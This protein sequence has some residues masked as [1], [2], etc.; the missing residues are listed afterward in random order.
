MAVLFGSIIVGNMITSNKPKQKSDTA[1]VKDVTVFGIGSLPTV[2][3]NATVEKQGV[4]SV[5]AQSAGIVQSIFVEEGNTVGKGQA[6]VWLSTNPSGGTIPSVTREI[7][8]KNYDFVSLNYDTQKELIAKRRE[9]SERTN[10]LAADT[11]DMTQDTNART[12]ELISLNEGI[13]S[14]L[15]SQIQHLESTNVG[16]ANESLILQAKQGKS[17]V[18]AALNSLKTAVAQA[19][20]QADE[21]NEP[22]HLAN[23]SRDITTKQLDLEEKSLDLNKELS[24]LNLS[25]ALLSESLLYPA[26]PVSG[27]VERIHVK[28]GQMVSAGTVIATIKGNVT[29]TSLLAF[30]SE[31]TARNLSH[32][33]PSRVHIGTR[34]VSL[35]PSYVSS[36]PTDGVLFFARYDIP[37]EYEDEL[38]IGEVVRVDMPISAIRA[39]SAVPFVP[40]DAVYQ[41]NTKSYVFVATPSGSMTVAKSTVVTLGTVFGEYVEV[42]NGL[43]GNDVVITSR[44]VLDGDT[45]RYAH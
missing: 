6:L 8:Q 40:L 16:N 12:N 21:Q 10:N 32:L 35:V 5:I 15:D 34:V 25:I 30:V 1:L 26:S 44:T 41:S 22:G 18:L 20:Y 23:L 31:D 42:K 17:S 37:E 3:S 11:R 27:T 9:V 19:T 7:A 33:E 39:T 24:R 36:E 45:V 38:T 13:V 14:S 2:S 28:N 29:H 43:T 4:V